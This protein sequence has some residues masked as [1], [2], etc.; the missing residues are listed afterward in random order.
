M[1]SQKVLT[2]AVIT[3][4][5]V[6]LTQTSYVTFQVSNLN[7]GEVTGKITN[8]QTGSVTI[9]LNHPPT[10]NFT[11]NTT[12]NQNEIY[13]CDM[14]IYDVDEDDITFYGRNISQATLFSSIPQNGILSTTPDQTDVDNN[15]NM[16]EFWLEDSSG[17][18]NRNTT[19]YVNFTIIDVNDPP[20]LIA[21]ISDLEW[22][23]GGSIRGLFLNNFF[24]DPDGDAMTY[25][26]SVAGGNFAIQILSN[27]EIIINDN[28]YCG[29]DQVIFTAK[30]PFNATGSSN[31]VTLKTT[32]QESP[33][34]AP[35]ASSNE[36]E[37]ICISLWRCDDWEECLENGTQR[38]K[39]RDISRCEE[40]Y[41]KYFWQECEYIDQC[42]NKQKDTNEDGVDCG[43]PCPA[44]ETCEDGL[45]NNL[46]EEV[47]C[48][49]PNCPACQNCNDGIQNY[50]E[51]GIDC[52]GQ[53]TACVSCEDGI[54]NQD[55]EGIDCGGLNCP[56]CVSIQTPQAITETENNFARIALIALA[57]ILLG[58][59]LFRF[60]V[61]DARILWKKLLL[62]ISRNKRKQILLTDEQ[63]KKLLD[64]IRL[65]DEKLEG[66]ESLTFDDH[67]WL[68]E[69][70]QEVGTDYF[71]A[72]FNL[73]FT[74]IR[75][76][77]DDLTRKKHIRSPL[78]EILKVFQKEIIM[79]VK[80]NRFSILD[81]QL[82]VEKI[83]QLIFST[84]H[85][86]AE[87]V[88]R[89][90]SE[91]EIN[92]DSEPLKKIKQHI[93]NGILALEFL[94]LKSAKEKYLS[95]LDEYHFL[96][97]KEKTKV[98]LFLDSFFL[99]ISYMKNWSK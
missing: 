47:D 62:F 38:K 53:C 61:H 11:C 99:M 19:L 74:E 95:S 84:S 23:E 98:Y 87:D 86:T 80:E 58:V 6:I 93:Y 50:G 28:D 96:S 49:G 46:E 75:D 35:S 25:T 54:K 34:S 21:T 90:V 76:N 70:I 27:S 57:L 40:D 67:V 42:Y 33:S 72:I 55:E 30:D 89:P 73:P 29:E 71:D 22:P 51:E 85:V 14:D 24:M 37:D 64:K 59:V 31:V 36:E 43:G 12:F 60:F 20:E 79:F 92:N 16:Y 44:C 45:L 10:I 65:L 4:F 13:T 94:E 18:A 81:V 97:E 91:I 5:I 63:K 69:T 26:A 52:G 3:L 83:R 82:Y 8:N 15:P 66:K 68:K 2:L 17:C 78:N 32:C 39:C 56:A 9:C 88:Q 77:F 48:G 41:K 7:S 1:I